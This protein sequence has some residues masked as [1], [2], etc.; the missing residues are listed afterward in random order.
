M[1]YSHLKN[2]FIKLSTNNDL[3]EKIIQ[4][5]KF[6]MRG[7]KDN[8]KLYITEYLNCLI[9]IYKLSII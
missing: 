2:L 3:V 9:V 4:L 1:K 8:F 5:I 6:Y 7:L